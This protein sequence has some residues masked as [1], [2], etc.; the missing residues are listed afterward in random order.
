VF[1]PPQRQRQGVLRERPLL[2]RAPH[3]F[4]QQHRDLCA[5]VAKG[6]VVLQAAHKMASQVL[7][8]DKPRQPKEPRPP[9]VKVYVSAHVLLF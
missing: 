9:R 1:L 2:T 6:F 5:Y 3:P 8:A 7:G 4:A